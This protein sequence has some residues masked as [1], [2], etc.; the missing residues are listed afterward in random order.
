MITAYS[1]QNGILSPTSVLHA[2]GIDASVVWIDLFEP[3]AAEQRLVESVLG[4]EV[5]TH[6]EMGEIELSSR[7]YQEGAAAFMTA[8]VLSRVETE[9]PQLQ[10][11][12]FITTGP[13]L[14]TQR[15][16]DPLPFRAFA[17]QV[18]RQGTPCYSREDVLAGLLD[19]IADRVA[20]ILERVQHEL[21]DMSSRVFAKGRSR[22]DVDFEE[23]LR[24][25]GQAQ[26]LTSRTRES[27]LSIARLI[28]FLN[29]PGEG[30]PERKAASRTFKVV[31]RDVLS[32]SDHATFLSNNIN[33]LLDASLGMIN[34]EQTGIIK[35][36]SVAAVVFLPPTLIASIYGMNFQHIPELAWVFGY[37]WSLGLMVLSAILPYFYFKRRGWL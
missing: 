8:L 24:Q 19:A 14:V 4:I 34:I 37:P 31:S 2:D 16:S 7:L 35:I 13:C 29:R 11:I 18:Q 23:V 5:P 20:D 9:T 22:G 10:P 25:L 3:T 33:F 17:A 28:T 15:Y 36:F 27:L 6:E 26:G 30:K 32:L 1:R 21:D 12:T